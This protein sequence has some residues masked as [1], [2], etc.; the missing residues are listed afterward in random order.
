MRPLRA[1]PTEAQRAEVGGARIM[2]T[3]RLIKPRRDAI[4]VPNPNQ[5]MAPERGT[6]LERVV[7]QLTEE[8]KAQIIEEHEEVFEQQKFSELFAHEVVKSPETTS[9]IS[10]ANDLTNRILARYGKEEFNIPTE[11]IHIIKRKEWKNRRGDARFNPRF[12][13]IAMS[14]PYT[15]IDLLKKVVHETLH[16][17]GHHA[18]QKKLGSPGLTEYRV[19]FTVKSRDGEREF[20][21]NIDEAV[22]EELTKE[23]VM[24]VREQPPFD[25]ETRRTQSVLRTDSGARRSDGTP[26]FNEDTYMAYVRRVNE[27]G[28]AEIRA[29]EFT[30][31]DER[32][33]LKK[34]IAKLRER[35]P[36]VFAND[37]EV[38]DLF[39]QGVVT[40]NILPIGRLTDKTFGVGTF[41]RIGEMDN[42]VRVQEMF[43]DAL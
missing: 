22:I 31:T 27:D 24:Q 40:G 7:G 14:E 6:S 16:F 23:A 15:K 26:L 25:K 3:P 10:L 13:D 29:G 42:D 43:I 21:R 1:C 18:V 36:G 28:S 20:F 9:I 35:N 2:E 8:K 32:R 11:N 19:G 37:R 38:F 5:Y 30:Y 34:L 39:A 12:Q 41:R 4:V 17:K 33:V